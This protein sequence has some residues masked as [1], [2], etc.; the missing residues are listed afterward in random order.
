MKVNMKKTMIIGVI[1]LF[2]S[3]SISPMVA[4]TQ[5]QSEETFAVEYAMINSDGSISEETVLFNAEEL[6]LFQGR[7]ST[8][9]DLLRSTSDKS[10]LFNLLFNFMNGDN[11]PVLSKIVQYLLGSDILKDRQLVISEGWGYDFNPF[12]KMSTDFVKPVTFWR[13]GQTSD[14]IPMPSTTAVLRLNP[15]EMK[16]Y[17]GGQLGVMFRFRGIYVHIPQQMPM[18]SFTFF[19]GSA[20]NIFGVEIPSMTLPSS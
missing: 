19:L 5:T 14:I 3:V 12:K 13:Y 1:A 20:K 16:T 4:A 7:L 6:S 2:I 9:F 17:T 10:T 18:Q 11:Y 15:F 8:L